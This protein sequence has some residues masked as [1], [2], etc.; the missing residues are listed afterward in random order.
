MGRKAENTKERILRSKERER[1]GRGLT[2]NG[3][4]GVVRKAGVNPRKP[5]ATE[6]ERRERSV[7]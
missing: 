3:A 5:K 4:E 6:S 1:G 7:V 2:K